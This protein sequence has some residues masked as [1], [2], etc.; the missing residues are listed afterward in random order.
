MRTDGG[1]VTSG[2]TDGTANYTAPT[3]M[4]TGSL[5]TSMNWTGFLGLSSVT[6]PNGDGSAVSYDG[7]QRP[8]TTT[9]PYGAVTNYTY[10]VFPPLTE[11]TTNGH[12]T[13][14]VMDGFGRTVSARTGYG[15]TTVSY[16]DTQ[17]APCACSPLGKVSAVSQPYVPGATVYWT[18]YTYDGIGRTVSVLAPDGGSTATYVYAGNTVTVTDAAGKWKK[19]TMD[20]FGNL[21]TVVEPD[22]TQTNTGGQ[23]TTTY[24]YD[25]LNHLI[26][27]SM[28]RQMPGGNTV[29]QTRTFTYSGAYLMSANNPESGTVNYGYNADGTLA[30]KQDM[31]GQ[32]AAYFLQYVYDSYGRVTTVRTMPGT[33]SNWYGSPTVLRTYT[34][35]VNNA[36]GSYSQKALGRLTTAGYNVPSASTAYDSNGLAIAFTNDLVTEMYSYSIAGQV[37]GKR[38][39]VARNGLNSG[40]SP[41]TI[42][43][44]L[45]GTWSYNNEGHLTGADIPAAARAILTVTMDSLN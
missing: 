18:K 13:I 4:T 35:D 24:T 12:W 27:V 42:S 6:G 8:L 16:T 25:A 43:A 38:L 3:A 29:T 22:A 17:Y 23:A 26:G 21:T 19:F 36:D 15:S 11:A 28:P 5:T 41:V 9:S 2:Q 45:N 32:A 7:A 20:A 14:S 39:R 44:D 37:A 31:K 40:G 1:H 10:S 30:T 33:P 34:Y